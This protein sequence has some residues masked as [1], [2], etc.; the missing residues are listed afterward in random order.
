MRKIIT[1]A[2]IAAA[3]VVLGTA[4]GTQAGS[5]TCEG[6]G[7]GWKNHGEHVLNYV[8]DGEIAGGAPAHRDGHAPPG[9]S[10]CLGLDDHRP[11]GGG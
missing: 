8:E 4:T 5:P 1:T 2:A 11:V 9:A 6:L 7:D 10:F 3:V